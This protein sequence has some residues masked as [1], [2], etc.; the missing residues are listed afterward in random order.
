MLVLERPVVRPFTDK[1]IELASTFADQAVIAMENVRLVGVTCQVE[2]G[3]PEPGLVG[4]DCAEVRWA[5]DHDP[6]GILRSHRID[7][8]GH[9][10]DH[11]R[12]RECFKVKLHPP[13]LDFGEVENVIDQGEEMP[14]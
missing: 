1:Q 6:I 9:V 2:Q 10:V 7:G 3:L 11:R 12:H 13:S 4:V 5:F 8:L 14:G